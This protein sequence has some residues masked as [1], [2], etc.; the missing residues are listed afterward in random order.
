MK[1]MMWGSGWRLRRSKRAALRDLGPVP[2]TPTVPA[3]LAAFTHALSTGAPMP[4][5]VEDGLAAVRVACALRLTGAMDPADD[6][7][8]L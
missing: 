6:P 5:T 3:T 2:R 4:V 8:P 7:R 1:W